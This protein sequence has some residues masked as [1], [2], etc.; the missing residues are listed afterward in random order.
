M[1]PSGTPSSTNTHRSKSYP[2]RLTHRWRTFVLGVLSHELPSVYTGKQASKR[3]VSSHLVNRL[4]LYYFREG[5]VICDEYGDVLVGLHCL[6]VQHHTPHT[7]PFSDSV[8]LVWFDARAHWRRG[9][10]QHTVLRLRS[11][12]MGAPLPDKIACDRPA[13]EPISVLASAWTWTSTSSAAR[14]RL[15]GRTGKHREH[16][17]GRPREVLLWIHRQRGLKIIPTVRN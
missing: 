1:E 16:G 11:I 3:T 4:R 10:T 13:L 15:K 5:L 6:P 7:A 8:R 17:A 12:S 9:R 2:I 14:E